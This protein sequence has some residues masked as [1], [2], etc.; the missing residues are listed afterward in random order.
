MCTYWADSLG[1]WADNIHGRR[2]ARA[3][4]AGSRGGAG[5]EARDTR[6]IRRVPRRR[7]GTRGPT[8]QEQVA[9]W[10][11]RCGADQ[12]AGMIVK[13]GGAARSRERVQDGRASA[14][15][16]LGSQAGNQSRP[17]ITHRRR[18]PLRAKNFRITRSGREILW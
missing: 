8:A 15:R 13:P 6:L 1:F 10:P 11:S 2:T 17:P 3:A 18:S 12:I 14:P 16:Y 4:H 5:G 7:A 9:G